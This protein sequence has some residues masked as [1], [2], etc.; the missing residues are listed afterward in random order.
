MAYKNI[1][2]LSDY[3]I[4]PESKMVQDILKR[5][6]LVFDT[7]TNLSQ[8]AYEII[9]NAYTIHVAQISVNKI[10]KKL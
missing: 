10:Y 2:D 5:E 6:S 7:K 1:T 8:L 3:S 4:M 9:L